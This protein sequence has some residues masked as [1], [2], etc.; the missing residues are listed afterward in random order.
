MTR[1]NQRNGPAVKT[2]LPLLVE[3]TCST[4]SFQRWSISNLPVH[5]DYDGDGCFGSGPENGTANMTDVYFS[6]TWCINTT[7]CDE[8]YDSQCDVISVEWMFNIH[9]CSRS[10]DCAT[11]YSALCAYWYGPSFHDALSR[12]LHDDHSDI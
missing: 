11:E 6:D 1:T 3:C 2:V 5:S 10:L 7:S 9:F 12:D 4:L 8:W